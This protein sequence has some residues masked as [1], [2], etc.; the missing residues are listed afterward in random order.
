MKKGI[1]QQEIEGVNTDQFDLWNEVKKETNVGIKT[2]HA[3]TRE[4]WFVRAGKNIGFEQDGKGPEYLRPVIIVKKFNNEIFLGVPLTSQEK[5]GKYYFAIPN[6]REKKN[7][8]ILSQIRLFS[9]KRLRYKIGMVKEAIFQQLKKA[10]AV[11][12]LTDDDF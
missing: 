3:H 9:S 12:I 5:K 7:T 4:I 10:I 1:Q 2:P 6:V 11:L 8:A